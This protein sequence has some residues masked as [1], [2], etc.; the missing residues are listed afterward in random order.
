MY[1]VRIYRKVPTRD[2]PGILIV[3]MID[4]YEDWKG[5][6]QLCDFYLID[7]NCIAERPM[8]DSEVGNDLVIWRANCFSYTS[9]NALIKA[10]WKNT[11]NLH[12]ITKLFEMSGLAGSAED[13]IGNH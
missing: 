2:D 1:K 7:P 9:W 10:E 6:D 4:G 11:Y 3:C 5:F 13:F 12:W 8:T